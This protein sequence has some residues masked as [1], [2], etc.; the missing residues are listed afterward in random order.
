MEGASLS[1][2]PAVA[3]AEEVAIEQQPPLPGGL[4]GGGA[5]PIMCRGPPTGGKEGQKGE[6]QGR[7]QPFLPFPLGRERKTAESPVGLSISAETAHI[8]LTQGESVEADGV[9][10]KSLRVRG[11]RCDVSADKNLHLKN[12][13]SY[14][15]LVRGASRL[16]FDLGDGR[17]KRRRA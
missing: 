5:A 2:H 8:F 3:A 15:A 14:A 6:G 9:E 4:R 11:A 10:K 12:D 16:G 7:K 17:A 13:R 1:K